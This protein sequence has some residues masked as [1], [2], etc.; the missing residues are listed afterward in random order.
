MNKYKVGNIAVHNFFGRPGIASWF[1][2]LGH[3]A[4][5]Q[6]QHQLANFIYECGLPFSVVEHPACLAFLK[7]LRPAFKPPTRKAVAGRL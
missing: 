2:T 4:N 7:A 6:L 3:E 5:A 1:D